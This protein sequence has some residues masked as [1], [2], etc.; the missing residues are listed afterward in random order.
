MISSDF[1]KHEVKVEGEKGLVMA[2]LEVLLRECIKKKV[3]TKEDISLVA[4]NS[5][6]PHGD[7]M[8]E[9]FDIVLKALGKNK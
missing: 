8:A 3:L 9:C 1:Y 6:K 4:E 5:A 2:E 7:R